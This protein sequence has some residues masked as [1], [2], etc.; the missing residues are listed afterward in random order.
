MPASLVYAVEDQWTALLDRGGRV[1]FFG[2]AVEVPCQRRFGDLAAVEAYLAWVLDHPGLGPAIPPV[3][4]RRR[5]GASRAHYEPATATIALPIEAGWAA[6]ETVVLHELAH[7]LTCE[8]QAPDP[9][10]RRSWHGVEF[11]STLCRLVEVAM[12]DG[13]A[14][15]LRSGYEAAGLRT[16]PAA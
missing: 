7:H 9:R 4:V 11:R 12:G 1:D 10:S 2:A 16:V 8:A 14:L 3:R 13:A 15:L 5:A 6:R